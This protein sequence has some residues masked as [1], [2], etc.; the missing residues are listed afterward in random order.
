M[1]AKGQQSVS[2]VVSGDSRTHITALDSSCPFHLGFPMKRLIIAFISIA[3][4]NANEGPQEHYGFV[5]RLGNDTVSIESVTRSANSLTSDEVD[6]FPRVSKRHTVISLA[7]DGSIK[8][9]AMDIHTPSEP[10]NQRDRHVEVDVTSDAVHISKRDKSGT[11]ERNFKTDG[12]IAMAH[13]PQMYSLYELYFAAALKHAKAANVAAGTPIQMRQFYID[14]EF[15]NFPLHHGVVR[16]MPNG[17]VD[18][19]HDWLSGTGEATIDSSYHLLHYSGARSTYKV[20]VERLSTP[21]NVASV[22]A[23]F[24][25]LETK[26]GGMKQLS[27]R[28]TTRATIGNATFT[29]DYAR[30]LARGR[31]LLGNLIP[32]EQVWRTG[33]NAATQF[34]TSAPITLAG[35]KL[36]AGKY[37]LW[38]IP[39]PKGVD[40]I[41]NKQTGQWGTGYNAAYDLGRAPMATET[42]TPVDEFT[43]SIRSAGARNG[44]LV[45]EWGPFRWTAPIVVQ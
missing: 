29:V 4:C 11:L 7:P 20:E 8:H 25:A 17:K 3:A 10:V 19:Q 26:N 1:S 38:T 43:I 9:L 31:V 5:A 35:L 22:A 15:D 12:G 16:V 40:L 24:A 2:V 14:R 33:A 32:Y 34:T 18:I 28:D 27:V 45:M 21:P 41:V 6:R 44:S 30:P 42:T 36:P 39:H 37:T 23:Q 13:L